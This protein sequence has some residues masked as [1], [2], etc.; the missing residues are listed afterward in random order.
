MDTF[1]VNPWSGDEVAKAD[2]KSVT[3]GMTHKVPD[4]TVT[5]PSRINIP[6][7]GLYMSTGYTVDPSPSKVSRNIQSV[8]EGMDFSFWVRFGVRID[9]YRISKHADTVWVALRVPGDTTESVTL[10]GSEYPA[11]E[12]FIVCHFWDELT[13]SLRTA[14]D[15]EHI[16][17]DLPKIH[18]SYFVNTMD[19]FCRFPEGGASG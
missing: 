4:M 5:A 18:L 3:S 16:D 2:G 17:R 6:D 19:K 1:R 10:N 8:L 7:S 15:I 12:K 11:N 14:F 9:D 13:K